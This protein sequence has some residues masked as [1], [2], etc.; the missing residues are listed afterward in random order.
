M[1]PFEKSRQPLLSPQDSTIRSIIDGSDTARPMTDFTESSNESILAHTR[2]TDPLGTRTPVSDPAIG[3][4]ELDILESVT[5]SDL[6]CSQELVPEMLGFDFDGLTSME[7]RQSNDSPGALQRSCAQESRSSSSYLTEVSEQPRYNPFDSPLWSDDTLS[8]SKPRSFHRDNT[9]MA[10]SLS[11]TPC[12]CMEKVLLLYEEIEGSRNEGFTLAMLDHRLNFQKNV[13]NRCSGI[14][15]CKN[16]RER[17]AI[18]MLLI[19]IC[20]RLGRAFRS[21]LRSVSDKLLFE[22]QQQRWLHSSLAP[23]AKVSETDAIEGYQRLYI[24][25][26]KVD[27]PQEQ[28]LL[29]MRVVELQIRGLLGLEAQL[30]TIAMSN[31]WEK[32]TSILRPIQEQTQQIALSL[33]EVANNALDGSL[34]C[35]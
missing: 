18:A 17:S 30:K 19:S 35:R 12:Q 34:H 3:E 23:R 4:E 6:M 13:L 20:E 14:L 25:D 21:L 33:K 9:H 22:R 5:A 8:H 31:G 28:L 27:A 29:V 1:Q 7:H 2:K 24:G 15:G 26:Y 32:H 16:C 11:M 10:N